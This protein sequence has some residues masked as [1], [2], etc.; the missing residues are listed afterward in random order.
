MSIKKR[1][2]VI[3]VV[4]LMLCVAVYLNW[5][6]TRTGEDYEADENLSVGKTLGEATLV[7]KLEKEDATEAVGDHTDYFAEARLARQKAR[8]E[9]TKMLKEITANEKST[10]ASIEKANAD[11][12]SLAAN[13]VREARIESLIKAKGFDDCVVFINDTGVNVIISKSENELKA[14]D[15]AKIKDIVVDETKVKADKIK[16][17]EAA[18]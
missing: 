6:Y 3:A 2:A 4:S 18:S 14:S 10:N 5:S 9:S 16:I 13:A 12:S 11:I 1:G 15:T 8:D 17:V 7:D